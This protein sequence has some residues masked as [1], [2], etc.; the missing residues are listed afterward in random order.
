[1]ANRLNSVNRRGSI[2]F[3]NQASLFQLA[4][5]GYT[6]KEG[7]AQA[8]PV[9]CDNTVV[10]ASSRRKAK[11]RVCNRFL[12]LGQFCGSA[13]NVGIEWWQVHNMHVH[14]HISADLQAGTGRKGRL[15][16]CE[17][18]VRGKKVSAN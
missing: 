11:L 18:S 4:E 7:K 6:I 10:T 3:F 5:L 2:V 17:L 13:F 14:V 8:K 9:H 12:Y 15:G 16:R 1:M